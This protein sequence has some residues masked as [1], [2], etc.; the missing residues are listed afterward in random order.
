MSTQIRNTQSDTKASFS[1][2]SRKAASTR[3][4]ILEIAAQLFLSEGYSQTSLEKVAAEAGTTKPTVYSHFKSKQGLFDAVISQHADRRLEVLN[5]VLVATNDV[6]VDLIQFGEFFLNALFSKGT[7]SWDRLA[8]AESI[9]HP[10]VGETFYRAGPA[11][12]IKRLSDYLK[13]QS[14][15]GLLGIKRP[16][17]AAEQLIGLLLGVDL[18]RIQIGQVPPGKTTQKKRVREAIDVFL[19]AY[20]EE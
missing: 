15:A 20:R 19:A 9:T 10:E 8:A 5:Q 3:K 11:R 18:L 4:R 14:Q 6:E 7:R 13:Q 2:R 12:L 17:R 16:D 1:E